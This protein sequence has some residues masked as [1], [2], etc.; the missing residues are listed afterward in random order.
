MVVSLFIVA[1]TVCRYIGDLR[2]DP[3]KRLQKI[4]QNWTI[5]YM[6]QMEFTYRPVLEH[7]TDQTEDNGSQKELCRDFRTVVGS[8]V[9]LAEPLSKSGLAILL[10]MSLQ[11]I[12][13]QLV[14]LHSVLRI[15]VDQDTPIRTLHL[16][17]AEFL[18][19]EKVQKQSFGVDG[20]NV[21]LALSRHCLR[22]LSSPRGLCENICDLECPGELRRKV[23][24][25]TITSRLSPVL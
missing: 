10:G 24:S 14:P 8:I 19:S 4:L 7:L 2:F 6:S 9:V 23:E 5:G 22:V 21:H 15:S 3:G 20:S 18:L 1:A 25:T 11:S 13:Q 16:S 17:F 12:S